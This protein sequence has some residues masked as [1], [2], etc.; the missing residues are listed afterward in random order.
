MNEAA[1]EIVAPVPMG[2]LVDIADQIEVTGSNDM[3]SMTSAGGTDLL[4]ATNLRWTRRGTLQARGWNEEYNSNA[5][6][7]NEIPR[8]A[9]F[10]VRADGTRRVVVGTD[11]ALYAFIQGATSP[12]TLLSG[13]SATDSLLDWNGVNFLDRLVMIHPDESPK[14]TDG[15]AANTRNLVNQTT[16]ETRTSLST[17]MSGYYNLH[18]QG[19]KLAMLAGATAAGSFD[20]PTQRYDTFFDTWKVVT[21]A[22]TGRDDGCG[23]TAYGKHYIF[24][25]LKS[26]GT[27]A[28]TSELYNPVK[29][30]WTPATDITNGRR[31]LPA[32][33][34]G[35][36]IYAVTGN[37]N[38]SAA[39]H[40]TTLQE[41]DPALDRWTQ[42]T[43]HGTA[44]RDAVG[45]GIWGE[46][47][48][49]SGRISTGP[50]NDSATMQG[51]VPLDDVWRNITDLTAARRQAGGGGARDN[52][53]FVVGGAN[54]SGTLQT[55]IFQYNPTADTW[56]TLTP[57]LTT[58][59]QGTGAAHHRHW[60]YLTG[61]VA[62][63]ST[64]NG[65]H[66]RLNVSPSPP[67]A[68]FILVHRNQMLMAWTTGERSRVF[69]APALNIDQ[70]PE[71]H[72]FDVNRNDGDEITG[73]FLFRD[74]L[75]VSKALRMYRVDGAPFDPLEA[76]PQII[77]M[78]GVPGAL[79]HNSIVVT[80]Q[81][82][83]YY[84]ADGVRVF[85]GIRSQLISADQN[86]WFVRGFGLA[87]QAKPIMSAVWRKDRDEV[88]FNLGI[89][90]G[91][92][93]NTAGLILRQFMIWNTRFRRWTR[94]TEN[95]HDG[96]GGETAPRRLLRIFTSDNEEQIVF[97][98]RTSGSPINN[99]I[100]LADQL[101]RANVIAGD[102]KGIQFR[103][104]PFAPN[105]G[106]P[107]RPAFM[108]GR[109]LRISSTQTITFQLIR[110]YGEESAAR[111][112]TAA[113][114]TGSGDGTP[115]A[116]VA[117]ELGKIPLSTKTGGRFF[118]IDISSPL[119]TD[120]GPFEMIDMAL[121]AY[122]SNT[123]KAP[124]I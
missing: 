120:T 106:H 84:A 74:R 95:L 54:S 44:R 109:F 113:N 56:S 116:N 3:P 124:Q 94:W 21:R 123:G 20:A 32:V 38:A 12:T 104:S 92:Q 122:P 26:S 45:F 43:A 67:Q 39:S 119:A 75:Y 33:T 70:Y 96:T 90:Y 63:S 47:F 93:T 60:L 53:G 86:Y 115:F 100:Y 114:W 61:G 19:S 103:T 68:R 5:I 30:A 31:Q 77:E 7:N 27:F 22:T 78:D 52:R 13:L 15:T 36:R 16:L 58:A 66:E 9:A 40:T 80:D 35:F 62:A 42:R 55:Q 14:V 49:G 71:D 59:K 107:C 1:A 72:N 6:P 79:A 91:A 83:Y 8:G 24:T 41:Y 101:D 117:T 88:W 85:D 76:P 102:D 110:D 29:D 28:T 69:Y 89:L 11:A 34:A 10:L 2:S 105:R 81:G 82:V 50:D 17:A 98:K 73:M 23:G 64:A 18:E 121:F 25:G 4:D 46:A 118:Q 108:M 87:T 111:S 48:A 99:R 37:D 97:L 51:Y 112:Y 57:T 65:D